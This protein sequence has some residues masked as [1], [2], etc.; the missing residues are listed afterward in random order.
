MYN[1]GRQKHVRRIMLP[2]DGAVV[3]RLPTKHWNLW[4]LQLAFFR[5][6]R[7]PR[8]SQAMLYET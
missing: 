4:D 6:G 1:M 3:T 7:S 8:C 2:R 5:D